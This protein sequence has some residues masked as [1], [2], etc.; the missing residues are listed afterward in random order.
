MNIKE[1]AIEEWE[2]AFKPIE[3]HISGDRGWNGLVFET[4]GDD[5]QFVVA[6]PQNRIW[7]WVDT[8]EGSVIL[9][10]Y[11]LVNRIGYFV[12]EKEWSTD[13][14]VPVDTHEYEWNEIITNTTEEP[15]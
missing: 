1:Q 10:G 5:L 6:Q 8:D 7:T 15:F 2:K 14:E 12:T 13:H 11:H 4:Y 9:S 3:N